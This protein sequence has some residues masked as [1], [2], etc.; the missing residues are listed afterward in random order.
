MCVC[1]VLCLFWF[2]LSITYFHREMCQNKLQGI[3]YLQTRV[4]QRTRALPACIIYE[5][6][7]SLIRDTI[8]GGISTF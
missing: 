5:I 8:Y 4:S 6:Y 3:I 2:Y 1:F 7:L